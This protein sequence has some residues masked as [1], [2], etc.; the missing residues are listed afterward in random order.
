MSDS[1]I[2]QDLDV[3]SNSVQGERHKQTAKEVRRSD[4]GSRVQRR[5]VENGSVG[6]TFGVGTTML[7]MSQSGT[8]SIS[9]GSWE[10]NSVRSQSPADNG[11]DSDDELSIADKDMGIFDMVTETSEVSD[12]VQ[13]GNK[14]RGNITT[15]NQQLIVSYDDSESLSL[16]SSVF[17]YDSDHEGSEATSTLKCPPLERLLR[18]KGENSFC[19]SKGGSLHVTDRNGLQ[20]K[21]IVP[22]ISGGSSTSVQSMDEVPNNNSMGRR[23]NMEPLIMEAPASEQSLVLGYNSGACLY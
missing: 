20:G 17:D 23:T 22:R 8:D 14:T 15:V 7:M 3:N 11:Q 19:A 6:R 13:A 18:T 4:G 5:K 1:S 16:V 9:S 10:W 2:L 12:T 21:N